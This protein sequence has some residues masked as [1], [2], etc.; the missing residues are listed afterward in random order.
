MGSLGHLI[1]LA[2]AGAA[3]TLSRAGI[4]ILL[5]R[6]NAAGF[7]WATLGVNAIGCFLAGLI[8]ALTEWRF[9]GAVDLRPY[10]LTGFCGAFTTVSAYVLEANALFRDGRWIMAVGDLVAQSVV[11]VLALV[12]GLWIGRGF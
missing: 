11:G 7:P 6:W 2:A 5:Q 8:W 10:A 12:L 4:S 1:A 9:K 3:G